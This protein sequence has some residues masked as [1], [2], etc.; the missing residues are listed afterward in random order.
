LETT[1]KTGSLHV[2]PSRAAG[3]AQ[4]LPGGPPSAGRMQPWRQ[5]LVVLTFISSDVLLALLVWGAAFIVQSV[6]G[7][8]ALSAVSAAGI[9]PNIGVWVG[10]RESGDIG[11]PQNE[12]LRVP[13]G[14]TG[15]RQVAG[16]NESFFSDRV[17]TDVHYVR[18]WSV[19]LDLV[20]LTRTPGSTVLRRGAY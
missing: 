6:W 10:L 15:L 4:H 17:R 14:I 3:P 9:A 11:A 5:L 1:N 8:G 12:I 19:W 18:N 2:A 13:P 20:I 16:R 7:R